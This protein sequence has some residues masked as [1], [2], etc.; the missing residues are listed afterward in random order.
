MVREEDKLTSVLLEHGLVVLLEDS[1]V[2]SR[3][4]LQ[5]SVVQVVFNLQVYQRYVAT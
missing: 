1:L 2:V 3:Y 5:S 4:L